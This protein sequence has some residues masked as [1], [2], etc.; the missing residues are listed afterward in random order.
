M[1]RADIIAITGVVISILGLIGSWISESVALAIWSIA[2]CLV[3]IIIVG[4]YTIH[5]SVPPWTILKHQSELELQDEKGERAIVTKTLKLRASHGSIKHYIHRNISCDG[6]VEFSV[7]PNVEIIHQEREA[8]DHN[9]TVEFP[10]HIGRLRSVD[11]WI[12]SDLKNT[13]LANKESITIL[14]D[15][16]TKSLYLRV[17]FPETRLPH[18]G[19]V[20][21]IRRQPGAEKQMAVL[22]LD[23]NSVSWSTTRR[24]FGIPN[25][26]YILC[27][28]W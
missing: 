5:L 1:T 28:L 15:Q 26:E 13:F 4:A 7:D 23:G 6:S 22:D 27:W 11:T 12:K 14:I 2:L 25:G 24:L 3:I 17:T 21:I 9:V 20:K 8:G 16:P 18:Q 10:H 19:T